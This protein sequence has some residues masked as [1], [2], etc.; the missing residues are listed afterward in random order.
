MS[1][2]VSATSER[3][4]GGEPGSPGGVAK[5]LALLTMIISPVFAAADPNLRIQMV[6]EKEIVV[7]EDGQEVTRR[8]PTLEIESGSDLYFTLKI[9]NDGDEV[10]T[11]VV[12]DN[13]IPEDTLYVPGSA[14]GNSAQVLF[15]IDDG[16]TFGE[17]EELR[18]EFTTFSG[19][20]ETRRA[21]P[22]QYTDIRWVVSDI[23]PGQDEELFFKVK[24]N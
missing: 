12:V 15:S 13:P 21:S 22:E 2:G 20:T 3:L 14:G 24:V 17:P 7:V 8:V 5:L 4:H 9:V 19:E 18:Y 1:K 11:N 6:A 10:A 23:P 16:Q